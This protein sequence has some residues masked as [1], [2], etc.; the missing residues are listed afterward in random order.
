MAVYIVYKRTSPSG[1]VYIGLTSGTMDFRAGVNG[2]KYK[3]CTYF[4][5]AIEKYGW[6]NFTHEIL[7]DDLTFDEACEKE[8]EMIAFYRS[9]ER[10]FGYNLTDG[11]QGCSGHSPSQEL[12][13]MWS[14]MYTGEGNPFYGKKH[15][16]E[17]KNK[18]SNTN[19]GKYIGGNSP[20]ARAV[21]KIDLKT[22]EVIQTYECAKTASKN[23]TERKHIV[24]CCQGKRRSASGYKWQYVDEPH[25]YTCGW[26]SLRSVVQL[27]K[28]TNE[29]ISLFGTMRDAT[30]LLNISQD[31]IKK[32]CDGKRKSAGGYKWVYL[33][34]YE[35]R[36]A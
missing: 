6:N 34:E 9:N 3:S 21:N 12:K 4:W 8:K 31:T 16:A 33:D 28:D 20:R 32:V 24:E 25:K 11:G 18:I 27:D 23:E 7:F 35:G 19:K 2:Y 30:T 22:N 14:E 13:D 1:K 36:V 26:S 15:T 10:E 5:S 17:V 29:F